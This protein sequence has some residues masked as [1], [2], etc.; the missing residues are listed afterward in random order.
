MAAPVPLLSISTPPPA[1]LF[2]SQRCEVKAELPNLQ[3]MVEQ[4]DGQSAF[5][6]CE[7]LNLWAKCILLE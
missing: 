3:L 5:R 2:L 6:I 4:M 1:F 7:P